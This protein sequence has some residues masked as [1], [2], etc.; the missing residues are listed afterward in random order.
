MTSSI[1]NR[2]PKVVASGGC[3]DCGGRCPY[4]IHV[5][6]GKAIRIEPH[7]ELKACVRGYCYVKRVY[8][9]DRLKYPMKRTG[10]RGEG[11]FER[12]S[13]EEALGTVAKELTRGK[14]EYGTSAIFCQGWSGSPGRFHNPAPI[15]RLLN[16]FGGCVYRWGSAS[17]E[18]AYFAAKVTF[19]THAAGHTKDDLVHS[20]LIILWGLNPAE[21]H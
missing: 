19:G 7:E 18:A 5:V 14:R 11:V 9:P 13:W 6:E 10:K 12:I 21:N 3:H 2:N 4:S 15:Y 17:A 1:S 20:R 16:R 8:A